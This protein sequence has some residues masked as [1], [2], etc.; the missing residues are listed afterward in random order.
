MSLKQSWT[1]TDLKVIFSVAGH[2]SYVLVLICW[3]HSWRV[4]T[5]LLKCVI[6]KDCNLE[7]QGIAVSVLITKIIQYWW[8]EAWKGLVSGIGMSPALWLSLSSSLHLGLCTCV[9][10][11]YKMMQWSTAHKEKQFQTHCCFKYLA[12]SLQCVSSNTNYHWGDVY[13]STSGFD[14]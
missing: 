1:L 13:R 6:M 10:Q 5:V 2:N 3:N 11:L 4:K 12:R 14:P 7:H 9:P 8:H